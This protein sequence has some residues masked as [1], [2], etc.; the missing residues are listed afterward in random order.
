VKKFSKLS[1]ALARNRTGHIHIH[2]KSVTS[3]PLLS[4]VLLRLIS[5][6]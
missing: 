6:L 4:V 1:G 3:E 2:A 5:K